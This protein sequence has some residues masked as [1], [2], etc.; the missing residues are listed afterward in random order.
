MFT[1]FYKALCVVILSFILVACKDD[2]SSNTPVTVADPVIPAP[3]V[4]DR[5]ATLTWNAPFTR[6]N[7]DSISMGE[8]QGYIV[9]YSQDI[10]D[11]D[12]KAIVSNDGLGSSGV[13]IDGL[14][15]GM[16]YF[17]VQTE[18]TAGLVSKPS[19]TVNKHI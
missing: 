6:T 8:I 5:M 10:E 13:V 3:P 12:K 17:T 1:S 15:D 9:R 19:D 4:K 11:M 18:D 7:G 2:G 14:A 16:W